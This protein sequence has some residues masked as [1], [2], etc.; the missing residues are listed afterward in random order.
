MMGRGWGGMMVRVI[1]LRAY[2][3]GVEL[4]AEKWQ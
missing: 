3:D 1:D 2:I 4:S